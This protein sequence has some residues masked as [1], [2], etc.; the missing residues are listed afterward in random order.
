MRT[1]FSTAHSGPARCRTA[2][3]AGIVV[4]IALTAPAS[5]WGAGAPTVAAVAAVAPAA[6]PSPIKL[7]DAALADATAQIQANRPARAVAA[8]KRVQVNVRKA[9]VAAK[10]QI[11]KPPTDPESDD[12][13]GPPAVLA[14]LGLDRRVGSGLVPLYDGETRVHLVA[15]LGKVMNAMQRRRNLMLDKVIALPAEGDG[16]DYAD[17][18]ADKLGVFT[19]EVKQLEAALSTSNLSPAGRTAL[20][21]AHKRAVATKAKVDVAFGGGE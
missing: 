17:G 3:V 15:A 20:E 7:A 12:L 14:A 19:K 1:L 9:N 13:P 18:L 8:L 2:T 6:A 4:A 5:S 21:A 10:N 16:A 11:G